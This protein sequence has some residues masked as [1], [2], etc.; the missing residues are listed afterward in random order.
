MTAV[1]SVV[2][3]LPVEAVLK[4]EKSKG[5]FEWNPLSPTTVTFNR[6]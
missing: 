6:S 5:S 2:L 4:C 3:P 1:S